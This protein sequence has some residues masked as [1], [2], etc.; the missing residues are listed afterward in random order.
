[1]NFIF[2]YILIKL[3]YY[4]TKNYLIKDDYHNFMRYEHTCLLLNSSLIFQYFYCLIQFISSFI[5]YNL[6][7]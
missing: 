4:Q 1:M 6:N 5:I 2:Y 3:F 7:Q